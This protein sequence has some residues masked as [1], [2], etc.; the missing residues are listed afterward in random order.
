M[1]TKASVANPEPELVAAGVDVGRALVIGR[2][3]EVSAV[4]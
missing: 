1:V 4:G 3:M 2:L